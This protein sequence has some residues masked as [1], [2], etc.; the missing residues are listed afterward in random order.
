MASSA[1]DALSSV[2]ARTTRGDCCVEIKRV[3]RR[4]PSNRSNRFEVADRINALLSPDSNKTGPFWCASE[5]AAC[6][7]IPQN[8]PPEPFQTAQG[9]AVQG[10]RL[11]DKRA[12]S[13]SPFRLLGT[14]SV[15]S[16]SLTG[17]ARLHQL[18]NDPKLAGVSAGWPFETGWAAKAKWLPTNGSRNSRRTVSAVWPFETGWA[19][20]AKWL[21]AHVLVLHAEIYPSVRDPLPDEIKDRGQVRA[22]WQKRVR[23]RIW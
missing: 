10:L 4:K 18:R 20:K 21:P 14:A 5:D 17:I 16:Q 7:H 12:R 6:Q 9:Y 19:A 1:Y 11:A 2:R 22:M 8:R 3:A 23:K 13:G 15:G